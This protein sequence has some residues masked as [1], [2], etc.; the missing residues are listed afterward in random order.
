MRVLVHLDAFEPLQR[1]D[2]SR[3]RASVARIRSVLDTASGR[4]Q[5]LHLAVGIGQY[6]HQR[7][8]GVS[9]VGG[10]ALDCV[11]RSSQLDRQA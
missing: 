8:P 5:R 2:R 3:V 6:G 4:R 11:E 1:D 10:I 9:Q 7:H